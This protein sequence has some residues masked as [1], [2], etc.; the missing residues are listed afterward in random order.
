MKI[1]HKCRVGEDV[2]LDIGTLRIRDTIEKITN[3]FILRYRLIQP[4]EILMC[5]LMNCDVSAEVE[6]SSGSLIVCFCNSI[7]AFLF[8]PCLARITLI[9]AYQ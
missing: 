2:E 6:V 7:V 3:L 4:H 1:I 8:I 9:V 5:I